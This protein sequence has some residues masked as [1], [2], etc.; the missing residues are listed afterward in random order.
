MQFRLQGADPAADRRARPVLQWAARWTAERAQ[1][2]LATPFR[3]I[4]GGKQ[5]V[6]NRL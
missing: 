6:P 2:S 3:S 4:R 1:T 5:P